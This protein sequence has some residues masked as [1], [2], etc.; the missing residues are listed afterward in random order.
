[1]VDS[2]EHSKSAE[3]SYNLSDGEEI[4]AKQTDGLYVKQPSLWTGW[5]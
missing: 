2:D 3:Y 1:M 5:S 4:M